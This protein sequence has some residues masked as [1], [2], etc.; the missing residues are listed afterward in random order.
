MRQEG[1][2]MKYSPLHESLKGQRVVLIDDSIVR[3]NTT[4]EIPEM[5][6][7]AGAKEV[8]MRISSPPTTFPCFYGIDFGTR[9]ELIASKLSVARIAKHLGV[10]SLHYLS[11]NGLVKST[12]FPKKEFC[13]ACFNEDYPI[14]LPRQMELGK[15]MLERHSGSRTVS[16]TQQPVP[17]LEARGEAEKPAKR[18]KQSATRANSGTR[19]KVQRKSG[20]GRNSKK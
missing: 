7:E 9:E 12:G 11:I 18:Q 3:G 10:D 1:V 15:Y 13:L 14:S 19:R 6:Y 4:R 20:S 2:Q 5:L 8:H 16:G 17:V